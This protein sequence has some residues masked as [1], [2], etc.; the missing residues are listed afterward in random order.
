MKKSMLLTSLFSLFLFNLANAI[1]CNEAKA[2]DDNARKEF[3]AAG[4]EYDQIVEPWKKAM[5][6]EGEAKSRLD[7]AVEARNA[8]AKGGDTTLIMQAL[9]NL[10]KLMEEYETVR[11]VLDDA[12]Q[13]YDKSNGADVRNR[14]WTATE[15]SQ[16]ALEARFKACQI[17]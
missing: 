10:N 1:T 17:D 16:K 5:S 8:A 14:Y 15:E 11:K 12:Q 7:R 9:N 13:T 6:K 3:I 4:K 2:N